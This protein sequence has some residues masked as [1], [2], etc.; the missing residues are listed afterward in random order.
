MIRTEQH[1]QSMGSRENSLALK[2]ELHLVKQNWLT[3]LHGF[4]K[5]HKENVAVWQN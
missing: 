5:K 4:S 1:A 3:T 2:F